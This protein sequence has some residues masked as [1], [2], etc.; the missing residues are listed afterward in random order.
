MPHVSFIY[1]SFSRNILLYE[2]YE[3]VFKNNLFANETNNSSI[4]L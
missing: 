2:L 3:Y 1:I 4:N